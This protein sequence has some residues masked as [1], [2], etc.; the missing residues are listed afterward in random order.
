M[1][2]KLSR[3]TTSIGAGSLKSDE[4]ERLIQKERYKDAVKQAKLRYKEAR[5][6]RTTGCS[7]EL[8]FFGLGSFFSWGCGL[9][10]LRWLQH[11][12][13]FGVTG[14]NGWMNSSGCLVGL[15]CE[16]AASRS[17]NDS[18][19]PTGKSRLVGMAADQAVLHPER[20]RIGFSR[21]GSRCEPGS[22]VAGAAPCQGRGRGA[23]V[24]PGPAAQL[25]AER[26]EILRA[27]HGGLLS[28]RCRGHTGQLG[29]PRFETKGF[30]DRAATPPASRLRAARLGR[31]GGDGL[32]TVVF[33]EPVIPRLQQVVRLAGKQEWDKLLRELGPLR[34]SLHRIDPRLAE[35][36]TYLLFGS[37]IETASGLSP[38]DA[39]RLVSGFMTAAEPMRIDPH[40]N[41]LRAILWDGPDGDVVKSHTWWNKY[42]EDLKTLPAFSP[43][44]RALAQAMIWR[45]LAVQYRALARGASDSDGP[46]GP[47]LALF[48]AMGEHGGADDHKKRVVEC[49]RKEHR[50]CSR[51]SAELPALV[52][53]YREWD[54]PGHREAAAQRLL[55]QFPD[56]LGTLKFLA[57]RTLE[58]NDPLAALPLA[59]KA[60]RAQAARPV[61]ARAGMDDPG[62]PGS[63]PR[64]RQGVGRGTRSISAR[65][66]AFA[67]SPPRLLLP[68]PQGHLRGESRPG[69]RERPFPRRSPG[70]SGRA[71]ATVARAHDR[72]HSLPHAQVHSGWLCRALDG[73]PQEEMPE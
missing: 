20:P 42:I 13:D 27:R 28:A 40:W 72:V 9:P 1:S 73:G 60:R 35:R 69:Q 53:A 16:K 41:R 63:S 36:L 54:E 8:T 21:A 29:P 59:L 24:A 7:S 2:S 33:G 38:R 17:R 43:P 37:L 55:D 57:H 70:P 68:C 50:A 48:G 18:A 11:L 5:H 49:S 67:R 61:V 51:V 32:E 56:D 39:D 14:V 30:L 71:H 25:A 31:C 34:Q 10:R 4:V 64:N 66:G 58:R 44:E 65:G 19:T 3:K 12:L 6:R 22:P 52:E 26:M 45:H 23:W 46:L 62:G 15:G 47:F